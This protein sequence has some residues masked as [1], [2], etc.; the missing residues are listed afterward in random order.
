MA[1]GILI[2][3]VLMVG[4]GATH[5]KLNISFVYADKGN[6]PVRSAILLD[7]ASSEGIQDSFLDTGWVVLLQLFTDLL[8]PPTTKEPT[9]GGE[10][11]PPPN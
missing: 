2:A 6:P 10:R 4:A 11:P 5:G 7:K 9:S 8:W 3:Y 1:L